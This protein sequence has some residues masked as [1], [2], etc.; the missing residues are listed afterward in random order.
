[1]TNIHVYPKRMTSRNTS[2]SWSSEG[3]LCRIV[4]TLGRRLVRSRSSSIGSRTGNTAA[5]GAILRAVTRTL[6]N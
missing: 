3:L 6:E 2:S 4:A 1:V 5:V